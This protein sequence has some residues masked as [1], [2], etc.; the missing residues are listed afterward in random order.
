M[1]MGLTST[2]PLP[3]AATKVRYSAADERTMDASF[4]PGICG[5]FSLLILPHPFHKLFLDEA[6]LPVFVIQLE[7]RQV[8]A[9]VDRDGIELEIA[10][11]D[12]VFLE[13]FMIPWHPSF[14]LIKLKQR[15]KRVAQLLSCGHNIQ[16]PVNNE[17]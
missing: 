3:L 15:H 8:V 10:S 11:A 14:I 2:P 6:N 7:V 9:S 4:F 16:S 13:P 17:Q 12:A 1:V 5:F